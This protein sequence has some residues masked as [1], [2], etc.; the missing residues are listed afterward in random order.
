MR[1]YYSSAASIGCAACCFM[2]NVLTLTTGLKIYQLRSNSSSKHVRHK[3][4]HIQ[5]D[6][7]WPSQPIWWRQRN[8]THIITKR[9]RDILMPSISRKL[10]IPT[11]RT[12]LPKRALVKRT[13]SS[14]AITLRIRD[15]LK[16]FSFPCYTIFKLKLSNFV[17]G[18]CGS[19]VASGSRSFE[20]LVHVAFLV[21]AIVLFALLLHPIVYYPDT[22]SVFSRCCSHGTSA[23]KIRGR[24]EQF[25]FAR[26]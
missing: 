20:N 21:L 1:E 23:R 3:H 19:S 9:D 8:H 5:D 18:N 24:R 10:I 22:G 14:S 25:F 7:L 4:K 2:R 17:A 16:D 13:V 15:A 6:G 11:K 26:H 12:C